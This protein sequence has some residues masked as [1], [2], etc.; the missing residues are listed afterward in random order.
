MT[1]EGV[2][3]NRVAVI[4]GGPGGLVAAKYLKARGFE[5]TLFEQADDIGGQWNVRS[6]HSGVW[7]SMRTN[8]SHLMTSMSD[9]PHAEGTAVYPTNQ[10]MH[11]YLR[12]FAETF[13]LT[14]HIRV[15]TRVENVE[16]AGT[17]G[18]WSVR[19]ARKGSAPA[20]E[21]YPRVVI[22]TGRYNKPMIPRVAGLETFSGRGG[23]THTFRYKDPESFRGQRVLVTGSRISSL[24]IAS[25]LA[26]L[27]AARVV[28]SAR[29][30]H[31]ILP[32]L[33]A[34]VP[35]EQI[36]FTRFAALAA[37]SLPLEVVARGFKEFVLRANGNPAQYGAP[38][39]AENIFEAGVTLCQHYL[40][41]VAERKITPRAWIKEIAGRVVRFDDGSEEEI[42]AIIFGTGFD[43]DLPFVSSEVRRVLDA[44]DRHLDLYGFTF[45]PDLAGLAFVGLY[46]QAGPYF[47]TLEL[48]ARWIAYVWGGIIPAPT[49]ETMDAGIA[50]YRAARGG[51][52]E[53]PFHLM[54]TLFARAIGVEPDPTA[55]PG[56]E[57]ALLFGPLAGISF[58]L[59]GPDSL[60]GAAAR[61][62]SD[63]A[64]FG[65]IVSPDLAPHE[66]AQ[67]DALARAR[68][69]AAL[70]AL[71]A[72]VA[73]AA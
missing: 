37:E 27:G 32:K 67:V 60:P 1:H 65:A 22:A 16:R 48:Q 73:P 36:A 62:A 69:D 9:L 61:Y 2:G 54:A 47:P 28:T 64:A 56:L 70:G 57:R 43:L 25:D 21:V 35:A 42:D 14:P 30:Q 72:R 41:L 58:R 23:V 59:Q 12:R 40:P 15:A 49:R 33:I 3:T 13:G 44:D 20:T 6:P 11:A 4:G 31:Y 24:E 55:W 63:A 18:G 66:R 51:P 52:N 71:A 10:E 19:S 34:G 5:P 38:R 46:N 26:M 7:P 29:R 17:S 39:P 45:H 53:Q 68:G 8:T 50:A